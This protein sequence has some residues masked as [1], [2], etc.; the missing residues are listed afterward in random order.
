MPRNPKC[1]EFLLTVSAD[2]KLQEN[3]GIRYEYVPNPVSVTEYE[4]GQVQHMKRHLALW[5]DAPLTPAFVQN[6]GNWSDEETI[7]A[8]NSKRKRV[9]AEDDLAI[10]N[11]APLPNPNASTTSH[12]TYHAPSPP[13]LEDLLPGPSMANTASYSHPAALN[14]THAPNHVQRQ[15]TSGTASH[16][17]TQQS[18]ESEDSVYLGDFTSGFDLAFA[19]W[20]D[21]E[22]ISKA[23]IG[24]LLK[25]PA[26]QPITSKL[27]WKSVSKMKDRLKSIEFHEDSD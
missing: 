6:L 18:P 3:L 17:I 24:R 26:M 13:P 27:S 1:Y 12:R 21:E 4:E 10:S 5:G 2:A 14:T 7:R 16:S 23:A 8:L 15:Q 19:K 11:L 25:D 9:L 22:N 20:L